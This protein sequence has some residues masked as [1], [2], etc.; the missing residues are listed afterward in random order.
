MLLGYSTHNDEGTIFT[1]VTPN[2]SNSLN[3]FQNVN[4]SLFRPKPTRVRETEFR[5]EIGGC[6]RT[7]STK[8]VGGTIKMLGDWGRI[9][10][11]V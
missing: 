2:R 1:P 5:Y 9:E 6:G 10:E 11:R 4:H 3:G 8:L 7:E